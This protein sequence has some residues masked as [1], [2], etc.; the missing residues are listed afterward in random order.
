M[1]ASIAD[2]WRSEQV[3]AQHQFATFVE[4]PKHPQYR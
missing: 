3:K 4:A 2:A 1:S